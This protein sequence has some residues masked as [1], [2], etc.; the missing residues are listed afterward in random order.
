MI[1]QDQIIE[2]PINAAILS[3]IRDPQKRNWQVTVKHVHREGNFCADWLVKYQVE[4]GIMRLLR[5]S[6][7]IVMM[8]F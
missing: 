6:R 3:Q 4:G 2:P 1:V 8:S 7:N 5:V